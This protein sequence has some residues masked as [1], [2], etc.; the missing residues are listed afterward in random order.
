MN[1]VGSLEQGD[2]VAEL[3]DV[4]QAVALGCT[5]SDTAARTCAS[6][7]VSA[8]ALMALPARQTPSGLKSAFESAIRSGE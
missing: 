1:V 7:L 6:L 5:P 2:A 8:A 4:P 3:P